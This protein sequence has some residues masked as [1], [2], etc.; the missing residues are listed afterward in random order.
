MVVAYAAVAAAVT[1]L[2][3]VVQAVG[4]A[5]IAAW[6]YALVIAALA[7]HLLVRLLL[8]AQPGLPRPTWDKRSGR[9]AG[10][11]ARSARLVELERLLV[12]GSGQAGELHTRVRPALRDIATQRLDD[13]RGLDLDHSPEA[14]VLLGDEAWELLRPDRPRPEHRAA[15]GI[16][17][18]ALARIVDRLEAL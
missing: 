2:F 12:F 7:L 15:R 14:R 17:E 8:A 3:V 13:R 6:A 5:P 16:S 11:P 18:A 10:L 9:T 4:S 1:A